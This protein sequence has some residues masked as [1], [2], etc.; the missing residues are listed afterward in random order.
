MKVETHTF[1]GTASYTTGGF[2]V[3]TGLASVDHFKLFVTTPGANLVHCH[4]EYSISGANV[5]V[6]I[7]R[8]RYDQ[9]DS[10]VGTVNSLPSGVSLR[11][12]SG[13]T[14]VADTVHTHTIN[15]D[16]ASATT[17]VAATNGG[18][19]QTAVGGINQ[20]THTHTVDL[21]NFTGDTVG[22]TSHTHTWNS[23]YQ[24]QHSITQTATSTPLSELPNAT[25]LSGATFYYRAIGS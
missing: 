9:L 15:H 6:K 11:S 22:T 2:T 3:A 25:D 17:D 13:G 19:V 24:H 4:F 7:V 8:H 23:L 14:Y 16:H 21:P 12:S 18:G 20:S 1:T 10:P 5:T